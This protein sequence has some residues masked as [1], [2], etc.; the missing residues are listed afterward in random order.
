MQEDR[1]NNKARAEFHVSCYLSVY[2]VHT[3]AVVTTVM[4][5]GSNGL[6]AIT[7]A[8][9]ELIENLSALDAD[10]HVATLGEGKIYLDVGS[11]GGIKVGDHFQVLHPGPAIRD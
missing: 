1:N 10:V 5:L 4:G 11:N 8:V 6:E 2:N 9:E 3:G 7:D